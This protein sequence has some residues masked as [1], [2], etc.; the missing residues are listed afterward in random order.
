[1]T[2]FK[3]ADDTFYH[4]F[5]KATAKVQAQLARMDGGIRDYAVEKLVRVGILAQGFIDNSP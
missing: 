2:A 3:I 5:P 1:M 4:R